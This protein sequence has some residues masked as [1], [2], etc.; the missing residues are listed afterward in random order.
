MACK[1]VVREFRF[2]TAGVNTAT[3]RRNQKPLFRQQRR[4]NEA[5]H[6]KLIPGVNMFVDRIMFY[7]APG[8][9]MATSHVKYTPE[10]REGVGHKN[11]PSY[12]ASRQD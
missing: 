7:E 11:Q 9:V 12:D 10:R 3:T 6:C 2:L 4:M 1:H 5:M 8:V